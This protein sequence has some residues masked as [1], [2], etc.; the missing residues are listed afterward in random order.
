ME[1]KIILIVDDEPDILRLAKFGLEKHGY[2]VLTAT[3]GQEALVLFKVAC[4]L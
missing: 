3:N 1:K 2:D 4:R